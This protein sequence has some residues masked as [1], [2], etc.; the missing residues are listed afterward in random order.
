MLQG[1]FRRPEPSCIPGAGAFGIGVDGEGSYLN[2][3]KII[4]GNINGRRNDF[5]PNRADTWAQEL[6]LSCRCFRQIDDAIADE[7]SPINHADLDRFVV[8]EVRH[9]Q[10]SVERHGAMSGNE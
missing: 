2:A 10:P 6:Q 5:K 9:A 3:V 7:R 8:A 1:K 4:R